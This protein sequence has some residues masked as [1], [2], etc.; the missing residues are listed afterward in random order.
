MHSNDWVPNLAAILISFPC[1]KILPDNHSKFILSGWEGEGK[2]SAFV[3]V[4]RQSPRIRFLTGPSPVFARHQ[5]Q[6]TAL[7]AFA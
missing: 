2:S 6:D 4:R 7:K 3:V 1:P 5:I